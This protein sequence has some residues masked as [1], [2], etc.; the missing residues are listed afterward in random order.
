MS[1]RALGSGCDFRSWLLVFG[2]VC[3]CLSVVV[4]VV[5]VVAA[6]AAAIAVAIAV[7]VSVS[8]ACGF[9]SFSRGRLLELRVGKLGLRWWW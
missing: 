3:V 7:V 2:S 8:T 9:S 5:V 4:V 1:G 6:A